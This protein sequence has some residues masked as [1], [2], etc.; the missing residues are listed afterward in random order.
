MELYF[1]EVTR[2][3]GTLEGLLQTPALYADSTMTMYSPN[4]SPEFQR[5]T[6]TS[7]GRSGI[8]AQP[9][10]LGRLSSPDQASPVRR[11]VFVF[12]RLLC[13][14]LPPPP[15][16][17]NI[18][19]PPP[20]P[21]ATNRERFAA[22]GSNP[23][24][25]GCHERIDPMGFGFEHFDGM[26]IWREEEEG[27]P[28]DA[29]GSIVASRDSALRGD[30]NG[31]GELASRLAKSKQVHECVATEWYRWALGRVESESD[32]CALEQIQQRFFDSKGS[33][34]EL[35]LAIIGSESFLFRSGARR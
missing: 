12:D 23:G 17:L 28:I 27:K 30:F 2:R 16:D 19:P 22:H 20:K 8:L 5:V 11:G 1:G 14:S 15:A 3:G 32:S 9:G 33:F 13:Q 6:M 29:R 31:V 26:G 7:A 35:Q 25:V 21:G 18:V 34:E 10:L 4:A 24:C